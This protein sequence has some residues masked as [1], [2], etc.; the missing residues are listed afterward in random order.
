MFNFFCSLEQKQRE[1]D[2]AC[3]SVCF[4]RRRHKS[5]IRNS[6]SFAILISRAIRN[7]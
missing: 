4:V 6:L 3:L 5:N 7:I 2:K 1:A